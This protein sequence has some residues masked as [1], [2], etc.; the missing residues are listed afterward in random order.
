MNIKEEAIRVEGIK[1][2]EEIRRELKE[3]NKNLR[4]VIEILK[5]ERET[6]R[7]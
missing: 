5:E 7:P 2:H 6:W 3:V 4:S 1:N